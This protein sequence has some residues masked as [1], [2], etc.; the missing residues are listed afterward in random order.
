M[1]CDIHMVVEIKPKDTTRWVGVLSTG[2]SPRLL[3]VSDRRSNPFDA[4]YNAYSRSTA[5]DDRNYTFFGKLAGVRGEGPPANGLPD[6]AS[7]L[8]QMEVDHWDSDGHSH[9]HKPLKEFAYLWWE[10][11]RTTEQQAAEVEATL[12]ADNPAEHR[13]V[14]HRLDAFLMGTNY[15]DDKYDY[16]VVFWF[17]N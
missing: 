17:D 15:N 4:D 13:Y 1:G 8:T 2:R 12:N 7:E 14:G 11:N 3:P 6:D 10:L 9:S 5:L 16:R